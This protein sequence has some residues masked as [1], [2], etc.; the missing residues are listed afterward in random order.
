MLSLFYM[1][2]LV[3]ICSFFWLISKKKKEKS[4]IKQ[5]SSFSASWIQNDFK[6]TNTWQFLLHIEHTSYIRTQHLP[7]EL[8]LY[9]MF[10][11]SNIYWRSANFLISIWIN[12]HLLLSH[13][14]MPFTLV[15]TTFDQFY[16]KFSQHICLIFVFYP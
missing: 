14:F 9:F 13:N 4:E 3:S 8:L 10:V 1:C 12:K 15:R 16:E 6:I 7:D 11:K 2:V 5:L